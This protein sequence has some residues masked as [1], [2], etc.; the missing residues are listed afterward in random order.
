MLTEFG[1]LQQF[2]ANEVPIFPIVYNN[3]LAAAQEDVE[4]IVL[5]P[6]MNYCDFSTLRIPARD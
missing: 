6:S 3:F 5:A 2:V 1:N 4:G